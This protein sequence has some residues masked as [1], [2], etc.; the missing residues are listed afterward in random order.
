MKKW[1]R[2]GLSWGLFMFVIMTFAFPYYN[3][4]EITTKKVVIGAVVWTI[5]GVLFG[6]SL[7]R[8][9]KEKD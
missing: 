5:G 6:L 8:N 2:A 9:Y 7:K 3:K 1:L 4:E